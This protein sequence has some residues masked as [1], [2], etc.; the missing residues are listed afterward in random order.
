MVDSM[1]NVVVFN[2]EIFNY[3]ELRN[4]LRSEGEKFKTETDTEVILAAYRK[5]GIDCFSKF[6]GMWGIVLYD[7]SENRIIASRDRFGI[8]PLYY[9]DSKDKMVFSQKSNSCLPFRLLNP[10]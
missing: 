1:N 10:N 5:W 2:G 3:I 4:Q 9:W 7:P 8:K 6:N